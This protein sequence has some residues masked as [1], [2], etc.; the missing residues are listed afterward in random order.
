MTKLKFK[1]KPSSLFGLHHSPSGDTR[2]QLI[3]NYIQ[4]YEYKGWQ[5]EEK[6]TFEI[7][8]YKFDKARYFFQFSYSVITHYLFKRQ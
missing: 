2:V 8:K 7:R 6:L 5:D 1:F 3:D 4:S